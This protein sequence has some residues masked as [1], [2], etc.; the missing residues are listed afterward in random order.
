VRLVRHHGKRNLREMI[1]VR[2]IL[3]VSRHENSHLRKKRTVRVMGESQMKN[4][5]VVAHQKMTIHRLLL[6][7]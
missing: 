2:N 4:V 3:R 5:N 6:C 1:R 7:T